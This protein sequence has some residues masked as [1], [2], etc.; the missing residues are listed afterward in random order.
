M[1]EFYINL[2]L[3]SGGRVAPDRLIEHTGMKHLSRGMSSRVTTVDESSRF[4]FWLAF[5]VDPDTQVAIEQDFKNLRST[6]LLDGFV[7]THW[8]LDASTPSNYPK[9][10]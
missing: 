4:S 10:Q 3:A 1:Q 2:S 7:P 8:P 9:Q 5:G 6:V